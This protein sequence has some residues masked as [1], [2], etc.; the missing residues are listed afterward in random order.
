MTRRKKQQK[1]S[2]A[3]CT[4]FSLVENLESRVFLSGTVAVVVTAGAITITGDTAD[5]AISI[6]QQGAP[7]AF[8]ITGANGTSVTY[9]AHT[10]LTDVAAPVTAV[11]GDWTINMGG[12]N[13]SVVAANNL[14]LVDATGVRHSLTYTGLAGNDSL[15]QATPASGMVAFLDAPI[16][17]DEVQTLTLD[18][19]ATTG[20]FDLG[21]NG[22]SVTLNYNDSAATIELALNAL[23]G[24]GTV[25]VAGTSLDDSPVMTFTFVGIAS[26][27][28]LTI[29]ASL[30]TGPTATMAVA[31]PYSTLGAPAAG[32]ITITDAASARAAGTLTFLSNLVAGDRVTLNDGA[33]DVRTYTAVTGTAAAGQFHIGGSKTVTMTNF[34]GAVNNASPVLAIGATDNS[35]GS[36]SLQNDASGAAG[37]KAIV[38]STFSLTRIRATGMT[39]GGISNVASGNTVTLS[40]G[41]HAPVVFTFGGGV[42]Q[43]PIGATAVATAG[44]LATAINSVG[45]L[46]AMAATDNGDGSISL[47]QNAFGLAGNT[48]ISHTGARI[49]SVDFDGGFDNTNLADGDTVTLDDGTDTPLVFTARAGAGNQRIPH[50]R[51]RRGDDEELRD[52]GERGRKPEYDGGRQLRRN[53]HNHQRRCRRVWQYSDRRHR[54]L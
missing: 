13:D 46:L 20:T 19:V 51:Q 37:N 15:F 2:R 26:P 36:C 11:T 48:T 45:G 14:S 54:F 44:N 30:L 29:D 32:S 18:S 52:R 38:I 24:L 1:R 31:T 21:Y 33:G 23:P 4:P 49:A 42:G 43:V 25:A 6:E 10:Y 41:I 34:V 40:D 16:A 22:N 50:R 8:N 35:D 5:N 17:Q 12:G 3:V 28:L 39:G 47:T 27:Q 7:G 53:L 9:N